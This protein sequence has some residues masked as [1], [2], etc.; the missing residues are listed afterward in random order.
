MRYEKK[1]TMSDARSPGNGDTCCS[2]VS[3]RLDLLPESVSAC[4]VV[5]NGTTLSCG[6]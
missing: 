1:R 2:V 4:V 5:A 3:T 6:F